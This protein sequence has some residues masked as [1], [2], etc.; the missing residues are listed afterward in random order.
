[1]VKLGTFG[2]KSELAEKDIA[3]FTIKSLIGDFEIVVD[4][5]LISA[6]LTTGSER[7]LTNEDIKQ[8]EFMDEVELIELERDSIDLILSA[9]Y[10][11]HF[12]CPE[13][14]KGLSTQPFAVNT[15][16][17][18][19]VMGLKNEDYEEEA[20]IDAVCCDNSEIVNLLKNLYYHDFIYQ[21]SENFPSEMRHNSQADNYA[22]DQMTSSIKHLEDNHYSVAAPWKVG[23]KE[24][25]EAFE[26]L[27]SWSMAFQ[28]MKSLKRKF[29]KNPRL[30][31]GSF[32]QMAETIELGHA[33]VLN[34]LSA[35]EESPVFYMP[36]LVVLHP[37][38]PNK[39]RICQDAAA[40]VKGYSL[41]DFLLDGPDVMNKLCGVL[42]RFRKKRIV[43]TAD[44]RNFFYQVRIDPLDRPAFRYLW[45]PNKEMRMDQIQINEPRDYIFGASCSPAICNVTVQFHATKMRR[46]S[47]ISQEIFLGC[48]LATYMDDLLDNVESVVEGLKYKRE[49]DECLTAGGFEL[50]KWKSNNSELNDLINP[51]QVDGSNGAEK[52]KP[53][54]PG[55]E[56]KNIDGGENIDGEE[57]IDEN[58]DDGGESITREN[59]KEVSANEKVTEILDNEKKVSES[60]EQFIGPESKNKVL[61]MGYSFE[62]DDMFVKIGWKLDREVITKRDLLSWIS[63]IYD[64]LGYISPFVLKGRYFFQQVNQ[65]KI[66]WDEPVPAEILKNF[67]IW[68]KDV[69]ELKKYRLPRWISS[70]EFEVSKKVKTYL[71]VCCD[72]SRTGYSACAYL[73]KENENGKTLVRFIMGKSHVVPL[74]TMGKLE[75]DVGNHEN[76]IPRLELMSAKIAAQIRDT[77]VREMNVVFD[78]IHMFSDSQ[79]VIR[80][81]KSWKRKFRTYENHKLSQIRALSD[82]SEWHFIST[83]ENPA[84]HGSKGLNG[85]DDKQWVHWFSGASFFHKP[86]SEWP[87]E[88]RLEE[89]DDVEQEKTDAAALDAQVAAIQLSYVNATEEIPD[90]EFEEK[91]KGESAWPLK[92]TEKIS[93]W[94]QKVRKLAFLIKLVKIWQSRVHARR[95]MTNLIES[96]KKRTYNLRPR[97]GFKNVRNNVE[98]DDKIKSEKKIF[99]DVDDSNKAEKI[100]FRAI[101]A[102]YLQK[103]IITLLKLGNS[104]PVTDVEL[105]KSSAKINKMTPFLDG[106]G[107]IRSRSRLEHSVQ[108]SYDAK[109]P[110]VLPEKECEVLES[111]VRNVHWQNKHATIIETYALLKKKFCFP[112]GRRY[113]AKIL[114]RCMNCQKVRKRPNTQQFGN[115]PAA[116]I[117]RA[118]PF[119]N[120]GVD[121]FG[122]FEVKVG[123]YPKKIW[124]MLVTCLCTRAVWISPLVDMTLDSVIHALARVQSQFPGLKNLFSD[125]GSNF[126]GA[127]RELNEAKEMLEFDLN[128]LNEKLCDKQIKWQF[129]PA[130]CGHWGGSWERVIGLVKQN[131]KAVINGKTITREEF[132]TLCYSVSNVVNRRPITP[133]SEDP[134]DFSC[135]SPA[136][137]LY[138]YEDQMDSDHFIPPIPSSGATL[139]S[140]WTTMQSL[141]DEFWI[142]WQNQLV[143]EQRDR[144]KWQKK[145][146]PLKKNALVMIMDDVLPRNR[147]RIARVLEPIVSEDGLTRRYLLVDAFKNQMER[148]REALVELEVE[149]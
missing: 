112:L 57:N 77:I 33:R 114:R 64:P 29:E 51:P 95:S 21:K 97:K 15:A 52:S 136:H 13:I 65:L 45:W 41:N 3:K 30:L 88:I 130:N 82:Q 56:D 59:K 63:T 18:W 20:Y 98:I 87:E 31:E 39:F 53:E 27:D 48:M 67:N 117:D 46:E 147:W 103:E 115:L 12:F 40:R 121:V 129:G 25:K 34:D 146:V 139:R 109:Y 93:I 120:S 71:S 133:V 104:G 58:I 141:L 16:F 144:P 128:E 43:I 122:P 132:T 9:K 75:L 35:P 118:P 60:L 149:Y 142:Q 54:T 23:R 4:D 90:V 124:A 69:L 10:A 135:L 126:K 28:R 116:R 79:T 42:L 37:D 125:Q 70:E 99:I 5:A 85:K 84:D 44:I 2:R 80:W 72:A 74:A 47:R 22:L 140:K 100:L 61:G 55:G 81:I 102:Q 76:S 36:N 26:G 91:E 49:M 106:E 38:K 19:V 113:V 89:N 108:L 92:I 73:H 32:A 1:M 86:K 105:K 94:P 62:E 83:K 101:Q 107:I 138:P 119:Q 14:K 148:H 6:E 110:I 66:E 145:T 78:E 123:R 111:L 17:G 131:M 143:M 7:P 8:Y 11:Y 127:K 68:K 137:F 24:T 50:T 134:D 96:E